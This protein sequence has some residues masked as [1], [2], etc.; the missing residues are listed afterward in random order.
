MNLAPVLHPVIPEVTLRAGRPE[1][2]AVLGTICYEAFRAIAEKHRFPAD[3]PSP[4]SATGFMSSMLS[5]P[6]IRSTVAEV[7][8]YVAGSNFLWK[9]MPVAAIGPIT[10]D[11]HVQN[12]GVGKQLME[13]ALKHT[14]ETRF[15]SIRL[16]QAAYHNRSLSLYTKLGFVV[17]EPLAAFQGHP[18]GETI[19]GHVIRR[20]AKS[21]FEACA[22]L[23]VKVHGHSR[24]QELR[25]AVRQGTATVVER[26]GRLTGYATLVGYFGHAVAETNDDL[27]ALI[28]AAESFPGPGFLLP[29]RNTE[30]FRWC[31]DRGLRVVQPMTLMSM[32]LYNEPAGAFL[33]SILF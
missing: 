19:P 4:E 28:A 1:D 13:D 18:I 32:G 17:R 2:A 11:S 3:F 7:N 8:G 21:D 30:V 27:K 25:D 6:D 31:L 26:A 14:R 15:P 22:R 24:R 9:Y 23:C 12:A 10:V 16:V 5:N 33:P 20:A 29:T